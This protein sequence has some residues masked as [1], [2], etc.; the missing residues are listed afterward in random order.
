MISVPAMAIR[1]DL[2]IKSSGPTDVRYV[3]DVQSSDNSDIYSAPRACWEDWS[4][5]AP[6]L[7]FILQDEDGFRLGSVALGQF[8]NRS[9]TYNPGGQPKGFTVTGAINLDA[10]AFRSLSDAAGGWRPCR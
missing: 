8:S 2:R 7:E 1:Y 4:T 10:V 9:G 3:L 6:Y 5:S